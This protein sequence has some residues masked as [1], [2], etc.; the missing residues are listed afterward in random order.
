M[1]YFTVRKGFLI[2]EEVGGVTISPTCLFTNVY[3]EV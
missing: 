2:P 3:L 1:K